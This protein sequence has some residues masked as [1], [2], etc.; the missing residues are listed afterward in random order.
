M[1]WIIRVIIYIGFFV[2]AWAAFGWVYD[3]MLKREK[4]MQNKQ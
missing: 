4:N 2:V 1:D 3:R